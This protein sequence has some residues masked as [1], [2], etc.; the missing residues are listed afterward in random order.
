[1]SHPLNEEQI[2]SKLILPVLA[3]IGIQPAELE[4]ETTFKI[5]LGRVTHTVHGDA[6][7]A[8]GRLDILCRRNGLSLLVIELKA[9]SKS[10]TEADRR[11]GLS[12]A[13]LLE[14]MAP[15]VLLSN[16]S[17]TRLYNTI[18]GHRIDRLDQP[19]SE[20]FELSLETEIALRFEA[21]K[22]FVGLSPGNLSEFCKSHNRV[23]LAPFKAESDAPPSEQLQRK[24][25]PTTYTH[26]RA[27]E[28]HFSRFLDQTDYVVFPVI[29]SSGVGKTNLLC[30]LADSIREPI[31]FYSG[32]FLTAS[33]L[34]QLAFDF[35]LVFSAQESPIALLKR[36]SSLTTHSAK[37]LTVILDAIDEWEAPNRTAELDTVVGLFKQLRIRLV[38]SCKTSPWQQFLGRKGV[39]SPL[40]AALF[41]DTPKLGNFDGKELSAALSQYS[42]LLS[43]QAT[44]ETLSRALENPFG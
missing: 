29:G 39:D 28:E 7:D 12:Y 1:V 18:T 38:V 35:N 2:K 43:L 21:L 15:F 9:E 27:V 42:T 19:F 11:Q 20:V 13:R 17:E 33:L 23:S 5:Q 40:K 4:L 6:R 30:F 14:P 34:E 24:F 41:P 3:A 36:I 32:T 37:G 25:I 8:S 44:S 26:R 16:G 10:L 22:L 31:L